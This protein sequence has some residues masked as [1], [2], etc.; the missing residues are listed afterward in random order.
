MKHK[1]FTLVELMIAASILAI[2]IV[3][4]SK[5]LLTMAGALD[6]SSNRIKAARFL[7]SKINNLQQQV[8]E[9]E[10][11]AQQDVR[12]EA[13][14]GSRQAKY[15]LQVEVLD[16][17]DELTLQEEIEEQIEKGETINTA[18]MFIG[19]QEEYKQKEAVLGTY[20]LS[21]ESVQDFE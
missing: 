10:Y 20:F 17:E 1:G 11:I 3:F 13:V 18:L 8:L 16:L 15:N 2:G 5:A 6:T 14:I 12:E 21:N 4:I 7:E 9:E 19:W